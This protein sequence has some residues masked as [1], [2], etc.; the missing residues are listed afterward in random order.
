MNHRKTNVLLYFQH[1]NPN[2]LTVCLE[3]T[4]PKKIPIQEQTEKGR[5]KAQPEYT[6]S[7]QHYQI[8]LSFTLSKYPIQFINF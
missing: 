4:I 6:D 3:Q 8:T 7:L 5:I 2:N 1:R